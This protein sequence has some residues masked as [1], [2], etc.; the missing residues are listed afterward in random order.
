LTV[1]FILY[2]AVL[3]LCDVIEEG[4]VSDRIDPVEWEEW[5]ELGAWS[6]K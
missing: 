2:N 3:D 1:A 5:A 4:T 6:T